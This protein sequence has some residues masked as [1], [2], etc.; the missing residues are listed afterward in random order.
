LKQANI[1]SFILLTIMIM[2][3]GLTGAPTRG[4][5]LEA[6]VDSL[7]LISKKLPADGPGCAV[8]IVQEGEIIFKKGYGLANLE[9]K[10]PI[11]P[12][13][14]FSIA[15]MSKQ[16][17][18][19][20]IL[21]LVQEG[22]L[23]LN[24]EIH[25]Y[26]PELPAYGQPVTI[27]Q[28]IHHTSGI[29]SSDILLVLAGHR[30]D[31]AFDNER[32]LE[33]IFRCHTLDFS[34]GA[35]HQYS[36]SGYILLSEIVRRVSGKPLPQFAAERIFK[37]LGMR[38]TQICDDP[39]RKIANEAIGYVRDDSGS[40]WQNSGARKFITLGETSVY[41]TVEDLARWQLNFL[42]PTVG[43]PRFAEQMMERGILN[44]GDTTNYAFGQ[45]VKQI[46]GQ[47]AVQHGGYL[48]G[49]HS[50]K[51]YLPEYAFTAI[52]LTNN[53]V[54]GL[55]G[56]D[57]DL[58]EIAL[59]NIF[60]NE[61]N[62]AD[63]TKTG[64]PAL[65]EVSPQ[66][67]QLYVGKY[68]MKDGFTIEIT[69]Q[70]GV[71]KGEASG[72]PQ[73]SLVAESDSLFH[74]KMVPDAKLLFPATSSQPVD[75]FTV[76]QDG[77]HRFERIAD[78]PPTTAELAEFAGDYYSDELDAT[79][80]IELSGSGDKFVMRSPIC[81]PFFRKNFGITGQDTLAYAGGDGCMYSVMP[82]KFQRSEQRKV[83]GFRLNYANR[84]R[85]ILFV[86]Q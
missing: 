83:T 24:D 68:Q 81:D 42:K 52:C 46:G 7:V 59:G 34:P 49:F 15:S 1:L 38:S 8:A 41:S 23:S 27:R 6:R 51:M 40:C 44:N 60:S 39:R 36:N 69:Y 71:L 25:Q 72:Q 57:R 84:L 74:I 5:A 63:S 32:M 19:A 29:Y 67:C 22:K 4:K 75:H 30:F 12:Q 73:F 61:A 20:C 82:I 37:P 9:Q 18:A 56:I 65:V 45:E 70:D 77:V 79:Y 3:T 76:L 17:T 11:G 66:L 58:A 78:Q 48:P 47:L 26:L 62:T 10:T 21:L 53:D 80:R 28:L 13:T 43:G 33:M 50:Y 16:F 64:A 2:A 55:G 31:E 14:V 35:E 54:G 85:N 86:K